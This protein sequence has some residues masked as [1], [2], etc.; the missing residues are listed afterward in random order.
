MRRSF[1][2][3]PLLVAF[4]LVVLLFLTV[5]IIPIAWG[6][7]LGFTTSSAFDPTPSFVGLEK[8]RLVLEDPGFWSALGWGAVYAVATMTLQ[9]LIGVSAAVLLHKHAGPVARSIV[10]LPYMIPAVTGVLAWKWITDSLYGILNAGLLG[11]GIVSEPINFATSPVWAMPLV[12]V[13]SV[14]QFTPFVVLVIL[15]N[16][17]TIPVTVYEAARIDGANWWT[18]FRYVTLPM[19]RS[20]ILLLVLLRS[21][22]MFNRFDIIWLLTGGGP[23]GATTT[24]P[25]YAYIQAFSE[26]DFGAAGAVSTVIFGILLVFGITYL[27]VFKPEREVVRG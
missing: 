20:A 1:R 6:I 25:V 18:E 12:V 3:D 24:L 15:A 13:A 5:K 27:G 7:G 17:S 22:W 21:I 2:L 9:I 8:F 10:L 14:W 11:A 16:L 26:N 4:A 19:L 23:R